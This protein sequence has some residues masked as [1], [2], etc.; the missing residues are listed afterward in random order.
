MA[1]TVLEDVIVQNNI[2]SVSDSE[3]NVGKIRGGGGISNH[4]VLTITGNSVVEQNVARISTHESSSDKAYGGGIFNGE[5]T[6]GKVA[7]LIIEGNTVIRNNCASKGKISGFGGGI[8]NAEVGCRIDFLSG[9]IVNN[10]AHQGEEVGGSL[11]GGIYDRGTVNFNSN[12]CQFRIAYNKATTNGGYD[13]FY[14]NKTHTLTVPVAPRNI[15]CSLDSGRYEIPEGRTFDLTFTS[16]GDRSISLRTSDK[17]VHVPIKE[18]QSLVCSF[19]MS[20]DFTFDYG[21]LITVYEETKAVCLDTIEAISCAE[22][23]YFVRN[24]SLVLFSVEVSPLLYTEALIPDVYFGEKKL[25]NTREEKQG[26]EIIYYYEVKAE[27]NTDL[28]LTVENSRCITFSSGDD[29]TLSGNQ[30][31]TSYTWKS[32]KTYVI[33]AEDAASWGKIPLTVTWKDNYVNVEPE[34]WV[35]GNLLLP[36][37][38]QVARSRVYELDLSQ[39]TEVFIPEINFCKIKTAVSEAMYIQVMDHGM[40]IGISDEMYLIVGDSVHM[41]VSLLD[42]SGTVWTEDDTPL[43]TSST[44]ELPVPVSG[45]GNVFEYI[46]AG[47]K[48]AEWIVTLGDK[49][50]T[51]SPLPENVEMVEPSYKP[52]FS[53][54]KGQNFSFVLKSFGAHDGVEPTVTA[55]GTPISSSYNDA[56][57]TY[58]YTLNV[59]DHTNISILLDSRSLTFIPFPPGLTLLDYGYDTYLVTAGKQFSF[60]FRMEESYIGVLPSI[61]AGGTIVI[62]IH[63]GNNIYRCDFM[64]YDNLTVSTLFDHVALVVSPLMPP[65]ITFLQ[66]SLSSSTDPE[67]FP[68][69][70]GEEFLFSLQLSAGYGDILPNVQAGA[71]LVK[72]LSNQNGRLNYS[73]KMIQSSPLLIVENKSALYLAAPPTGITLMDRGVGYQTEQIGTTFTFTVAVEEQFLGVIP[74]AYLGSVAFQPNASNPLLRTYTFAIPIF[75]YGVLQVVLGGL[76]LTVETPPEGILVTNGENI[77][78]QTFYLPPDYVF[79]FSVQTSGKYASTFPLVQING[80]NLSPVESFPETGLYK[81]SLTMAGGAVIQFPMDYFTVDIPS[82]PE[83]VTLMDKM[84][85]QYFVASGGDFSFSFQ[86]IVENKRIIVLVNDHFVA[87]QMLATNTYQVTLTNIRENQSIQIQTSEQNTVKVILNLPDDIVCDISKDVESRYVYTFTVGET[88]LIRFRPQAGLGGENK[89]FIVTMDGW[90]KEYVPVQDGWFVID[91]TGLV[92]D[93]SVDVQWDRSALV[94][95]PAGEKAFSN[96]TV[97]TLAGRKVCEGNNWESISLP[98]GVYMIKAGKDVRKV[99]VR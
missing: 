15:T 57:K 34:V 93:A 28:R 59:T 32:G 82:S 46:F 47:T 9:H 58:T 16:E 72:L 24:G 54:P 68:C 7:N 23:Q 30:G 45:N 1:T 40:W 6:G 38:T 21:N 67:V 92:T 2:G 90:P 61:R 96:F 51:F 80:T 56:D 52:Y 84:G 48:D 81:Y 71:N 69:L 62:P 77:A 25:E 76:A 78:G 11:G 42:E 65:G 39:N 83:G 91:L 10:I 64:V 53:V 17:K 87:S 99:V 27:E 74:V 85:G 37:A 5:R 19:T 79:S 36:Q 12:P 73:V 41:M 94:P 4:G 22:K 55:D 95:F 70:V 31:V 43:F 44:D 8:C 50:V 98:K 14:P 20:E 86:T 13:D 35:D 66:P 33:R 18:G 97:Y 26:E 29:F 49:I 3:I 60:R 75:E 89:S 63:E 88:S